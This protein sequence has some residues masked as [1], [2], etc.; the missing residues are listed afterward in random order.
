MHC[1]GFFP[2]GDPRH[3]MPDPECST[4]AERAKHKV[5][6]EAWD[7]GERP[8][9]NA[10]APHW[11][12]DGDMVAHVVPAGYGLGVYDDGMDDDDGDIW[13]GKEPHEYD[14]AC[15]CPV[16]YDERV[17]RRFRGEAA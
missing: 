5:D 8:N 6:C 12:G 1:Y 2:G 15:E 4:D 10:N 11:T 9:V 14:A 16:C 7:R 13:D 17:M 3:F